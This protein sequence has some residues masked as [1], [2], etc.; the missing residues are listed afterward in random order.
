MLKLVYK[1]LG[2]VVSVLGGYWARHLFKRVY[3]WRRRDPGGHPAAPQ[4]DRSA[5]CR[6]P[7]RERSSVC[8]RPSSTG[9]APPDSNGL[10]AMAK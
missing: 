6:P 8:S 4:L 5:G 1:P 9:P 7:G 3:Q 10:P 2:V